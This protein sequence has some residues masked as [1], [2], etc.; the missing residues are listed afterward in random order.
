MVNTT[1]NFEILNGHNW[2]AILFNRDET[3]S[4]DIAMMRQDFWEESRGPGGVIMRK[5]KNVVRI[6]IVFDFG[7][8]GSKSTK[9]QMTKSA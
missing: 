2:G 1:S 8:Q 7:L 9:Q 4:S 6:S 3:L 5:M